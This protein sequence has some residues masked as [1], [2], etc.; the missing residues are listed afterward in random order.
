MVIRPLGEVLTQMPTTTEPDVSSTAGPNFEVARDLTLLPHKQPAWIYLHERLQELAAD[1]QNVNHQI[2]SL[3]VEL[4][5][6]ISPRLL[7]LQTNLE[8]LAVSVYR[9]LNRPEKA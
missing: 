7:Q 8:I 5:Q 1:C 6:R 2:S 4:H 9:Y 3:P